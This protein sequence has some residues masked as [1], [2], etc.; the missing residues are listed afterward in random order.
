MRPQKSTPHK[1]AAAS[2]LQVAPG[3]GRLKVI[4]Q[5]SDRFSNRI[6]EIP[7]KVL[8]STWFDI[9]GPISGMDFNEVGVLHLKT[10]HTVWSRTLSLEDFLRSFFCGGVDDTHFIGTSYP[11]H[12]CFELPDLLTTHLQND[13]E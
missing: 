1:R 5:I 6:L 11:Y 12:F 13:L 7:W 9:S 10:D 2:V 8:T 3:L 4:G